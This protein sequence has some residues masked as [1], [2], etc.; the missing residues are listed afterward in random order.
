MITIP[1]AEYDRLREAAE[2]LA[3]LE[4]YNRIK[5]D[6]AAGREELIPSEF[7]D[8]MIDGESPVR[9]FRNLRGMTQSALAAAS[10]VNRVQIADIEA[11]RKT[12]S[13][14]TLRKLAEALRVTIDD[15]I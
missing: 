13:V 2:D 6:L 5:A 12:G 3:D 11:R 8:R 9:V 10:G 4:T 7:V 14:E 15:L 1:R